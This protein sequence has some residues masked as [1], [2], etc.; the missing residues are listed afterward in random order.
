MTKQATS[1]NPLST[2]AMLA[3][4]SIRMWSARKLDARITE[5]TNAEHG[6]QNDVMRVNKLL[7][8]KEALAPMNTIAGAARTFHYERTLPWIHKGAD[9]LPAS[10]FQ[11]YA[12]KMREYR[13]QFESERETFLS[14]Y[15]GYRA[16]APRRMNGAYKATDYP[17]AQV[18]RGKF[19]FALSIFP[20]PDIQDF[21]TQGISDSAMAEIKANAERELERALNEAMRD[22]WQRVHDKVKAVSE[23]LSAFK[24]G[25]N[26]ER[27]EG[28]FRDSLIDN[29]RELVSI[30]PDLNIMGDSTLAEITARM[31]KELCAESADSLRANPDARK[32]VA[33]SADAILDA[34]SAFVA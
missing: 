1:S 13:L 18:L 31:E 32:S 7:V 16:D 26:G 22:V 28:V 21:R 30:L 29:V 11:S 3:F 2:R 6:A 17:P 20:V 24:P 15:D 8:P 19:H 10:A 27:T 14:K 33:A 25:Q 12:D 4:P 9:L 34:V 23:K 5:E